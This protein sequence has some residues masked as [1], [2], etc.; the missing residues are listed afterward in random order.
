[1][2]RGKSERRKLLA[3]AALALCLGSC[4][5][6][7]T[8]HEPVVE[9]K[10]DAWKDSP[11][12][13]AQ[14]AEDLPRGAWW[15][16][17]RD[18]VLDGLEAQIEK[19]NPSLASALARYDQAAAY[20]NQLRSGLYPSI[21]AGASFTQNRQSDDRP[22][23]GA[24]QPNVYADNTVGLGTN[25]ELD[26]WGRVRNQ[27][28]A[29][30]A[31]AEAGAAD[32]QNVRLA[33]QAQLADDYVRLRGID[34]QTRLLND[35]VEAYARAL[36][37]TQNR[38]S[39][40]IASGLDVARADTQLRAVKA[41]AADIAAQRAVVEHA[42]ASLVGQPAMQFSLA[43]DQADLNAPVISTG[44]PSTLLQRRPDIAAAE[45]RAAAAN[46]NI[47]VARAAFYPSISLGM[48]YGFQNT[49]EA[50]LLTSPYSFWSI[51]PGMLLNLFDG[52]LR[53]ARLAQAKAVFEQAGAD[54]RTVVLAAFQQV[55]D[56]MALL[57]YDH[58]AEQEQ[59]QAVQSARTTLKLALNRYREGAVNYLEVVTAQAAALSAER[60]ALDLHTR[61][62]RTS[63][64]LVRAVG[65]GWSRDAGKPQEP[66]ASK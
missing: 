5:L 37:L 33:L 64:D 44:I 30:K 23:R 47:G 56:D 61:Q 51:G 42:I 48:S 58:D 10:S 14:P 60:S 26:L 15:Q 34:A 13:P 36:A 24:N 8:Y 45:R 2:S 19:A 7:P 32:V 62:L 65:G 53:D 57:K 52:G 1:M 28:A 20:L 12:Q 43:P 39:G 63:V 38:H 29:G 49:G 55:E 22:L 9:V 18:P 27:V 46:A 41:E 66:I 4:S 35:T 25:Y 6:A 59:N 31:S 21:D 16:V 50:A 3:A 11:W 40:G 54:Y 17:Y